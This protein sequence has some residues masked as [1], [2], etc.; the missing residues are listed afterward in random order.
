MGVLDMKS[1]FTLEF[2]DERLNE[3]LFVTEITIANAWQTSLDNGARVVRQG[4]QHVYLTFG[5][6]NSFPKSVPTEDAYGATINGVKGEIEFTNI[7]WDTQ[8][9]PSVGA[10]FLQQKETV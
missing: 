9:E 5:V 4:V 10:M 3:S 7:S 8:G 1:L 2:E 6:R